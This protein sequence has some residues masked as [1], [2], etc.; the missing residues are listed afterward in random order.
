[1]SESFTWTGLSP[2]DMQAKIA[3]HPFAESREALMQKIV[4]LAL[5]KSMPLTPVATGLL[6][7]SETTD[8]E[9]GG[10]RGWIGSNVE[11]APFVHEGT[12]FQSA[13][14]F[15]EQ[16]IADSAPE[17]D[18]AIQDSGDEYLRSLT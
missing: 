4:L 18:K 7:R 5:A 17:R 8:V 6:R 14:P 13:Q 2:A 9:P 11:Y 15:F 16:G 12:R 3:A 10:L 1:M